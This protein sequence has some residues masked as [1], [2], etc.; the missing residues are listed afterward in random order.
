[1][2]ETESALVASRQRRDSV[3][4]KLLS[5]G[6]S[7][8][9]IGC[10]LE[11]SRVVDSLPVRAPIGGTVVRF[12]AV[13]GQVVKADDPLIEI[14]DPT[15]AGIRLLVAERQLAKVRLGQRGRV[16]LIAD[17][18]FRGEVV[19]TRSGGTIG[20]NDRTLSVWA[21]LTSPPR[22]PLLHGMLARVA[23]EVSAPV[24]VLAVPREAVARDGGDT[25]LFVRK[26]DGVFERRPVRTGREDD[27]HA[28]IMSG[29]REGERVAV[30]GVSELQTAYASL[31]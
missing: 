18:D 17:P 19:V 12:Q 9:Q 23:L 8:E 29:L 21:D 13:L 10:V 14:H 7:T 27:R 22:T 15:G 26:D 31:R 1:M 28:E 2:R 25:F 5:L 6:L 11:G 20:G 3:R 16:R 30:R 4:R 24:D